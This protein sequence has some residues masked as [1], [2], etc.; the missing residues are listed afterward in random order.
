MYFPG[1]GL[2]K[3]KYCKC[4]FIF[5]GCHALGCF[6]ICPFIIV[7]YLFNNF[8]IQVVVSDVFSD[9]IVENILEGILE[10]AVNKDTPVLNHT[11]GH[12]VHPLDHTVHLE[13]ELRKLDQS[14]DVNMEEEEEEEINLDLSEI[15]IVKVCQFSTCKK[16]LMQ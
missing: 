11:Q 9:E 14:K 10:K 2:N 1:P 7:R 4:S 3:L 5:I 6:V 16:W 15:G 12:A 8:V 13:Q